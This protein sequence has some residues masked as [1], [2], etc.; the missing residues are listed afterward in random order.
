MLCLTAS[1]N[2]FRCFQQKSPALSTSSLR[3]DWKQQKQTASWSRC[4]SL[5]SEYWSQLSSLQVYHYYW[6]PPNVLWVVIATQP[7]VTWHHLY[8]TPASQQRRTSRWLLS[9]SV[10]AAFCFCVAGFQPWRWFVFVKKMLSGVIDATQQP[11]ACSL[12]AFHLQ[13][14]L[15][16]F[17]PRLSLQASQGEDWGCCQSIKSYHRHAQQSGCS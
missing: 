6:G 17:E 5:P 11:M 12:L 16:R 3:N 10:T 8:T 4:T 15:D 14:A 2:T 7:E 1:T 9:D 13:T